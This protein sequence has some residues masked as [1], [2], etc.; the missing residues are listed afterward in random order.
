MELI[1]GQLAIELTRYCTD[2]NEP[3]VSGVLAPWRLRAID[4]RLEDFDVPP[5]LTELS[6]LCRLSVRQ[7]TRGF[8]ASRG[9]SIGEYIAQARIE[10]AKKLLSTERSI[11][12]V[13]YTL[14][15]ASSSSFC[16][17]FRRAIGETPRQFKSR[18]LRTH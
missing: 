15:F 9:C 6:E 10:Q 13:A 3:T 11:K 8:R 1:S 5:T 16:F 2:N 4:E 12:A 7:L 14:G 18:L 17:A